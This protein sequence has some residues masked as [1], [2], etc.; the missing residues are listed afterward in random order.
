MVAREAGAA[1]AIEDYNCLYH[2][3]PDLQAD[4]YQAATRRLLESDGDIY[5]FTSMA[6][7]SH[8]ALELARRVKAARPKSQTI[9]GGPH[10]SAISNE[11]TQRYSW[12]DKVI[13]GEGEG[14]FGEYL[15]AQ[16]GRSILPVLKTNGADPAVPRPAYPLVNWPEYFDVNPN[17]VANFEVG[18]GCRYKCTFCYSPGFYGSVRDF[19]VE[20]IIDE[21]T[22]LR[23]FGVKRVFF[24]GDNFLNNR[25]RAMRLCSALKEA[26]LPLSWYCYL[27]LPDLDEELALLM[28]DAGCTQVF[29]GIDVVGRTAEHLFHKAFLRR[30]HDFER[31][32]A[33]L[34]GVGIQPTCGFILCPPSHAGSA[35]S[36]ATLAAA[37]RARLAGA[38]VLFNALNLYPGT[39]AYRSASGLAEADPLQSQLLMDVPPVVWENPLASVAPSLFPFHSRYV[40]RRE[41]REFLFFCHVAHTVVNSFPNAL[42]SAAESRNL[43]PHNLIQKVLERTGDLMRL[44]IRERRRSEQASALRVLAEAN[45]SIPG[46]DG[47]TAIG[48][49]PFN[50]GQGF[51]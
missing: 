26:R 46:T 51:W 31:K 17:R 25:E 32:L 37:V 35:G 20:G 12:V 5:G 16:I 1:V 15:R 48:A 40:G 23:D 19:G 9:F 6:V 45:V 14:P 39:E 36:E 27:T 22:Q 28:G 3:R 34:R 13:V 7:D 24:V 50:P 38:D 18:R 11:L 29:M 43:S 30:E 33:A 42:V 21:M 8:V 4:F 2:G 47:A 41:W 10:F 49:T 44:P